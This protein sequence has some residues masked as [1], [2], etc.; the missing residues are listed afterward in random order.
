MSVMTTNEDNIDEIGVR[1]IDDM[2]LVWRAA[3]SDCDKALDRWLDAGPSDEMAAYCS[4]RAAIDREEAAARDLQRL[5]EVT[6]PCRQS[7]EAKVSAA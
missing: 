2:Y 1:L 7:L 5:Y 3:E 4:Y 6:A